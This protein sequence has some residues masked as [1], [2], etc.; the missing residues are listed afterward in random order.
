MP[1]LTELPTELR[2]QILLL[3]LPKTNRVESAVPTQFIHLF[4]INQRLRADMSAV[5][6]IWTP[7]HYISHPSSLTSCAPRTRGWNCSRICLD[8]FYTCFLGRIMNRYNNR[9][10]AFSG[11]PELLLDWDNAV[12]FLPDDVR[13]I[14][15]DVTPAPVDKREPHH[16]WRECGPPW[17]D[18]FVHGDAAAKRFLGGHVQEVAALVKRLDDRYGGRVSIRLSGRL[19]E[20]SA[21]FVEAV[22]QDVGRELEFV[23]TWVSNEDALSAFVSSRL[24]CRMV[25]KAGR[26][27]THTNTFAWLASVAWS[28]ETGNVYTQLEDRGFDWELL[29][30]LKIIAS[31][32]DG[33]DECAMLASLRDDSIRTFQHQ[34]AADLGLSTVE[35]GDGDDR[36]VVVRR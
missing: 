20:K 19:S 13:E 21:F 23:G 30:S 3:V 5:S 18:L 4:H 28:R 12:P 33:N 14:W 10:A 17:F 9:G 26:C 1:S 32:R 31:F 24:S 29:E 36:H 34:V 7:I 6:S 2:Q 27:G 8:L 22:C 11:H 15:L 35:M 25:R 16:K